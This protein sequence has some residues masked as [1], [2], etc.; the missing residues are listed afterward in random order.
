[1]TM[2][3]RTIARWGA[4]T[5]MATALALGA[6]GCAD[7]SLTVKS[8]GEQPA[9]DE[10]AAAESEAAAEAQD[11][12]TPDP[13]KQEL[14]GSGQSGERKRPMLE[15][16]IETGVAL[17]RYAYTT[18]PGNKG[19][20]GKN[21]RPAY[22]IAAGGSSEFCLETTPGEDG[23]VSA[24]VNVTYKIVGDPQGRTVRMWSLTPLYTYNLLGCELLK[25]D[26]D[27]LDKSAPYE[28]DVEWRKDR[29]SYDPAP[30]VVLK[31]K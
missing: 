4:A 15:M 3:T 16:L 21:D 23:H 20:E 8:A 29:H 5:V 18:N 28:C 31:K 13:A 6:A 9:G 2:N 12:G 10:S 17:E 22:T 26:M 7:P 27:T 14:L 1:M 11:P 25:A 30:R 19:C 24:K